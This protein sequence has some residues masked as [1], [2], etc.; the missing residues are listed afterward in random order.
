MKLL[1]LLILL[2]LRRVEWRRNPDAWRAL[3][4]RIL[5]APLPLAA[6]VSR[7]AT[8]RL[9]VLVVWWAVVGFLLRFG[10]GDFL[11]SLPLLVIYVALLWVCIGR[12]TLGADI[13]EYLRLW[14]LRD[15]AALR[16]FTVSRFGISATDTGTL[17][18]GVLRALFVRGFRENF[19][20]VMVFAVTG[21]PGLL[22]LAVM[23]AARRQVGGERDE[24]LAQIACEMRERLDWLLVRM[25]GLT[26]LLTGNSSR[27]WPI[28]DSR[29]LDDEDPADELIADLCVAAAG[30]PPQGSGEPEVGLDVTDARGLLLRTQVVWIMLMAVSVII[31]F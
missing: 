25:L 16:E 18:R 23:D 10:L 24:L 28:L 19:G 27:A 14:Y 11:L 17:H 22:V 5:L 26:L 9:L 21:L 20:W 8:G 13:N 1:A 6:S 15:A 31:G 4:D 2:T 7:T 3:A 29:L 30:V 12:D